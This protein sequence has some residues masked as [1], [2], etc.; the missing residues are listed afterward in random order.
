MYN[1]LQ[2]V[3]IVIASVLALLRPAWYVMW[4]GILR[5]RWQANIERDLNYVQYRRARGDSGD[6]PTVG[7][8]VVWRR[9]LALN[10]DA[11]DA[12]DDDFSA[13]SDRFFE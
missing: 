8:S 5:R 2:A 9:N 1:K 10:D 13:S 6:I 11:L 12:N 4:R 3:T 7:G